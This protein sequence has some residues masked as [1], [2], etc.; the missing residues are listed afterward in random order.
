MIAWEMSPF[1]NGVIEQRRNVTTFSCREKG[2]K[3]PGKFP[4][5]ENDEAV[6]HLE[7]VTIA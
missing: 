1:W 5:W 7:S 4:I 2:G 3:S 6:N